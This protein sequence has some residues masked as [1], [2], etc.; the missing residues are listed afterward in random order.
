MT[1]DS[2][3]SWI[4]LHI[5]SHKKTFRTAKQ[6]RGPRKVC[7]ASHREKIETVYSKTL[8]SIYFS[9]STSYHVLEVQTRSVFGVVAFYKGVCK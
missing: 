7:F 3:E 9:I 8:I 6:L 4:K 5:L 1:Q 2:I